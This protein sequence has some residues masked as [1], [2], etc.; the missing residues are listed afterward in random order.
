MAQLF[1]SVPP[2]MSPPCCRY[3]IMPILQIKT[4]TDIYPPSR[5]PPPRDPRILT[6]VTPESLCLASNF[7]AEGPHGA[8]CSAQSH[9]QPYI[10][11]SILVPTGG[12]SAVV[13][14]LHWAVPRMNLPS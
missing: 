1:S 5:A 8:F 7:T 4:L 11:G 14:H 9:A 10:G 13:S 12:A 2:T 6:C 3:S